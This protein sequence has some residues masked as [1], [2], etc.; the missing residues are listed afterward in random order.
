MRV[1]P[2]A[3]WFLTIAPMLCLLFLWIW[4]EL[5]IGIMVLFT[6][7]SCVAMI[8]SISLFIP[9][10][11][12]HAN[13][14]EEVC[15]G[16]D[17]LKVTKNHNKG[18]KYEKE[19]EKV[20]FL[21]L[22][23]SEK[24][25]KVIARNDNKQIMATAAAL[26]T[27]L[28]SSTAKI[29]SGTKYCCGNIQMINNKKI[30]FT[31]LSG[32][33]NCESKEPNSVYQTP[34][35]DGFVSID[36]KLVCSWDSNCNPFALTIMV[37]ITWFLKVAFMSWLVFMTIKIIVKL[38]NI[39]V[40]TVETTKIDE[41]TG[42]MK[43]VKK[44]HYFS[45]FK[46]IL[47]IFL[48]AGSITTI[49]IINKMTLNNSHADAF[50]LDDKVTITRK[51]SD[52]MIRARMSN[53]KVFQN[54]EKERWEC[55]LDLDLYIMEG[56]T[57]SHC[58]SK[59]EMIFDNFTYEVNGTLFE[60]Q[61][62]SEWLH[63]T[64]K[65]KQ[66]LKNIDKRCIEANTILSA[67]RGFPL[68][69]KI[70]GLDKK[71]ED[72]K[73]IYKPSTNANKERSSNSKTDMLDLDTEEG[74]YI[75]SRS[76]STFGSSLGTFHL[77]EGFYSAWP[78][79]SID[80]P[81]FEGGL[82]VAFEK[83]DEMTIDT[84]SCNFG[85]PGTTSWKRGFIC[86][87]LR[88]ELVVCPVKS[89]AMANVGDTFYECISFTETEAENMPDFLNPYLDTSHIEKS[90]TLARV[91][92]DFEFE[93]TISFPRPNVPP[94]P[95]Y[96]IKVKSL[97]FESSQDSDQSSGQVKYFVYAGFFSVTIRRD[98]AL[99]FLTDF[100]EQLRIEAWGGN[101]RSYTVPTY[102]LMS[103]TEARPPS[104]LLEQVIYPQVSSNNCKSPW[105]DRLSVNMIFKSEV[106]SKNGFTFSPCVE[107]SNPEGIAKCNQFKDDLLEG[108][109]EYTL[110]FA[111]YY[112]IR[113]YGPAVAL[114]KLFGYEL[115]RI[116]LTNGLTECTDCLKVKDLWY[117]PNS[118]RVSTDV[119]VTGFPLNSLTGMY[120]T[121]SCTG[122]KEGFAFYTVHP[123]IGAAYYLAKVSATADIGAYS[124]GGKCKN[125][126]IRDDGVRMCDGNVALV[127]PIVKYTTFYELQIASSNCTL[128]NDDVTCRSSIPTKV[129][130][131]TRE[132]DS[133]SKYECRSLLTNKITLNTNKSGEHMLRFNNENIMITKGEVA[134]QSCVFK[135]LEEMTY[136]CSWCTSLL[137][138]FAGMG[139]VVGIILTIWWVL[140]FFNYYHFGLL[141]RKFRIT[142]FLTGDVDINKCSY[143]NMWMYS[144]TERASHS[145]SCSKSICPYCIRVVEMGGNK[146]VLMKK[147]KNKAGLEHHLKHNEKAMRRN[148]FGAMIRMNRGKMAFFTWVTLASLIQVRS[149]V[150]FE[151]QSGLRSSSIGLNHE[152]G[153]QYFTCNDDSCI[154]SG[155]I[156]LDLP[157][158][159]DSSFSFS[160]R[161]GGNEYSGTY[162]VMKS[163]IRTNCVYDYSSMSYFIESHKTTIKCT[164]VINC[165][166]FN[167]DSLFE[168]L[169]G[170][171]IIPFDT[172]NPLKEYYCPKDVACKSP[173]VG[174]FW[175]AE[176]C[177]S[178]NTGI[179]VGYRSLMPDPFK[180]LLSV[181]TCTIE[182]AIYQ[183]CNDDKC[184]LVST[185]KEMINNDTIQFPNIDL[186]LLKSFRVGVGMRQG[187]SKPNF[188]MTNPP[189]KFDVS[190]DG[191]FQFKT[192]DLPQ[193]STCLE[194]MVA[195]PGKCS[196]TDNGLHAA[197][198]CEARGLDIDLDL[199]NSDVEHLTNMINCNYE[200]SMIE[201][202]TRVISRSINID[203][204]ASSDTQTV[205]RPSLNLIL[206]HCN[207]G[208]H[209]VHIRSDDGMELKVNSYK[210]EIASTS[211]VGAYNRN[212]MTLLTIN[213]SDG[214]DG[215]L[216]LT[217]GGGMTNNCVI[218][219]P[220]SNMCNVTAILPAIYKCTYSGREVSFNCSGLTLM[221]PDLASG[222]IITGTGSSELNTWTPGY[223]AFL[224]TWWGIT[225]L[226][227]GSF[228]LLLLI[229]FFLKCAWDQI[230]MSKAMETWKEKKIFD[231]ENYKIITKGNSGKYI[232]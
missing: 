86:T 148:K 183:M 120:V 53:E 142:W 42:E 170:S 162:K 105:Q 166:K 138:M 16:K 137:V 1:K 17:M 75:V 175:L 212:G 92:D 67:R 90:G 133:N 187:E 182:E 46:L 159:R 169:A 29:I 221:D 39:I 147:F 50:K 160:T 52:K 132:L 99:S 204:I 198:E 41:E 224:S 121:S 189:N 227:V 203:G 87:H 59:G 13:Q 15:S 219:L 163:Q 64:N 231:N 228:L 146:Q 222:T 188:I 6:S 2:I 80:S 150:T 115:D 69:T 94:L 4:D 195:A 36:D 111:V 206:D 145:I 14:K 134:C 157:I 229:I 119:T 197:T 225:L 165:N 181:F 28:H 98:R 30:C 45:F 174:F 106:Y 47:I 124:L 218:N 143:C 97:Y 108:G 22:E 172:S 24:T 32:V 191:Y 71:H 177:V 215:M 113:L 51:G 21:M 161:D 95:A 126:Y 25:N 154:L 205:A 72:C 63:Y 62:N 8:C 10:T 5:E 139:F 196:I 103:L 84:G 232:E 116:T 140:N 173:A 35:S 40:R 88:R 65:G 12:M 135:Y 58:L 178:I 155:D 7:W 112:A 207:F 31:D 217:C 164:S 37:Y 55:E 9:K 27:G 216:R 82:I 54:I 128:N 18:V 49:I 91:Y 100:G 199:M 144:D 171:N 89:Y 44:H 167:K 168:G 122:G 81:N 220:D 61:T 96:N 223:I 213:P 226:T 149:Q 176:G 70:C 127:V 79:E 33:R 156:S 211:C 68:C 20:E 118:G 190:H 192:L 202:T 184:M 74:G 114:V 151:Q 214:D 57:S 109:E 34:Y 129:S 83:D 193:A 141:A 110:G 93:T 125:I 209:R 78:T 60:K 76:S 123:K 185:E 201:W 186:P 152:I 208:I 43:V 117:K 66:Q 23:S 131:C 19:E 210:G 179:A 104:H 180:P 85:S 101:L 56:I 73:Y 158:V 200:N 77:F 3:T 230:K 38:Y 130:H 107:D 102:S 153:N 194:G 26:F 11:A 48:W 136:R